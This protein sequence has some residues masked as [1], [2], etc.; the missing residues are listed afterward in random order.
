MSIDLKATQEIG[1]AITTAVFTHMGEPIWDGII[2]RTVVGIWD[3]GVMDGGDAL[4]GWRGVS[5]TATKHDSEYIIMYARSGDTEDLSALSWGDPSL[6]PE[7]DISAHT[8]R[9]LQIRLVLVAKV[10]IPVYYSY[11]TQASGGPVITEMLITGVT[12]ATASL[13]FTK[14]FELGFTPVSVVLTSES[15]VPVNSILRWAVTNTDSVNLDDYQWIDENSVE[16]LDL[17]AATGTKFKIVIEMSGS[18]GDVITVHE[19][20]AMFGGEEYGQIRLNE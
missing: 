18:T 20:A 3:S 9:Y 4:L 11:T 15:D 5:Y 16:N 2:P 17:L 19:F 6:N 10:Y 8:A 12:S 13:F 7:T 14:A 1:D